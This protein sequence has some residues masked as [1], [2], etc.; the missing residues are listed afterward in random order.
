M[1]SRILYLGVC[2]LIFAGIVHIIIILLIPSLGSRDAAKQINA[3]LAPEIFHFVDDGK[4]I[5]IANRDPFVKL[6]ICRFDLRENAIQITGT[7]TSLFWSASVFDERGRVIY[8]MNDR[9]AIN[10]QLRMLIVNPIQMADIRQAQPEEMESSILVESQ[11]QQGFVILRVLIRDKSWENNA[12]DF[13][14]KAEC[15]PYQTN[16]FIQTQP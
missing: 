10:N 15:V 6:S 2:G 8:S 7:Q 14:K 4:N 5:G 9:T 1:K 12:L 13:L 11:S 3:N 16:T